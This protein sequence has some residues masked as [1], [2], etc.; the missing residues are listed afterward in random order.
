L[1][2][3][4]PYVEGESL[5]GRL[6]REKQLPLEDALRIAAEVA[7]ALGFAHEH[8]VLHRDIKPGNILFEGRHAVVA[9]FGLARAITAA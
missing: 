1:Y 9:D 2:Y 5:A 4:M 3:V 8:N 6:D 7:D